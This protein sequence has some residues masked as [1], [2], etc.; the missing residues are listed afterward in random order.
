MA[1]SSSA[2]VLPQVEGNAYNMPT[3]GEIADAYS[4]AILNRFL[5]NEGQ[6]GTKPLY[7]AYKQQA[8]QAIQALKAAQQKI[9]AERWNPQLQQLAFAAGVGA[10]T[11]SGT[12]AEGFAKGFGNVEKVKE[13]EQQFRFGQIGQ[14][15]KLGIAQPE[16]MLPY[17]KARTE[18][19]QLHQKVAQGVTGSALGLLGEQVAQ[20]AHLVPD[21]GKMALAMGLRPNTPEYENFVRHYTDATMTAH[22]VASGSDVNGPFRSGP[23]GAELGGAGAGAPSP[24]GPMAPP[25]GPGVPPARPGAPALPGAAAGPPPGAIPQNAMPPGAAPGGP[26][27]MPSGGVGAGPPGTATVQA[28]YRY[29]LPSPA[30]VPMP[31]TGLPTKQA[32]EIR[33]ENQAQGLKELSES[34]DEVQQAQNAQVQLQRFMYLNSRHPTSS[35]EGVP[36]IKQLTGLE[37]YNKEMDKLA[38]RLSIYARQPGMG[39][40]TNLDLMTFKEGSVGRDKPYMVN[41]AIATALNV[42]IDNQLGYNQFRHNYF[43]VYGTLAGSRDAWDKYLN[44]NPIFDPKKPAGSFVL[45]PHRMSYKQ[46]FQSLYQHPGAMMRTASSP[47]L[48]AQGGRVRNFAR[49]GSTAE[50]P[51]ARESYAHHLAQLARQVEAGGLLNWGDELNARLTPGKYSTNVHDERADLERYQ[52]REPLASLGLQAAGGIGSGLAAMKGMQMLSEHL[53]GKEGMAADALDWLASHIP[54]NIY[55]RA[56]LAGGATGLASGAGAAQDMRQV[57]SMAGQQGMIG[58]VLGPLAALGAKYIGGGLENVWDRVQGQR[59]LPGV[60]KVIGALAR[61]ELKPSDILNRLEAARRVGVPSTVGDVGGPNVQ[62]LAHAVT[63]KPGPGVHQ[64]VDSLIER[65]RGAPARVQEV[66]NKGLAPDDYTTKLDQLQGALYGNA[67]PLYEE[68]YNQFPAVKSTVIH[69]IMGTP[70]GRKAALRAFRMMQDAQE[71]IGQADATG[72]IRNPSLRYLDY[73]KRALDDMIN[74][75]ERSGATSQG[76]I[77]RNMRNSLRDELDRATTLPGGTSPYAAARAQYAGDLEVRDALLMGRNQFGSMTPRALQ[78][79]MNPMS[80]AEKDAL[81]S[82]AAEYLFNQIAKT[83]AGGNTAGKIINTPAVTQKLQAMFD[84]PGDYKR[85]SEALQ[86]EAQNFDRAKGQIAMAARARN[87]AAAQSMDEWPGLHEGSY[88]ATLAAAGHPEWAGAR[89]IRALAAKMTP[90]ETAD[91]AASLLGLQGG[92]EAKAAMQLLQEQSDRLGAAQ[93]RVRNASTLTG[94]LTGNL[95]APAPWGNLPQQ[96]SNPGGFRRGGLVHA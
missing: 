49:G 69:D 63:Q 25:G 24:G 55:A 26:G 76:N 14:L 92:P 89:L 62:G 57:P 22:M 79:A 88:E 59:I 35:L 90:K 83:P 43:S 56:A 52:H 37:A 17:L 20:Q 81:R 95:T 7:R 71:P 73:T 44:A 46:Y 85:F 47:L 15:A 27:A 29:G 96:Q 34:D 50:A 5:Q 78:E 74:K 77:L 54:D 86:Q 3:A 80:W 82:G 1:N 45:N 12:A 9:G 13:A 8:G 68:A 64:Y 23:T 87:T 38:A 31:W 16:A 10:P 36:G 6:G 4:S 30:T 65:N 91:E 66:I 18:L 32:A 51:V 93:A 72:M 70:S 61:D 2:V 19:E 33:A 84:Q 40:M 48:R 94:A 53:H 11:R 58:A 21:A 39:R 75:E 67:K 60:K 41:K 28:A 42:A